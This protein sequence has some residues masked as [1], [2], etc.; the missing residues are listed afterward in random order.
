MR[1]RIRCIPDLFYD[2]SVWLA[3]WPRFRRASASPKDLRSTRLREEAPITPATGSRRS[4]CS[5]AG[6]PWESRST[7]RAISTLPIPAPTRSAKSRAARSTSSHAGCR[8]TR[9]TAARQRPRAWTILLRLP[10]ATVQPGTAG[11]RAGGQRGV[12]LS[13]CR[14][15][16]H[17]RKRVHLRPFQSRH[18]QSGLQ[19]HDQHLRWKWKHLLCPRPGQQRFRRHCGNFRADRPGAG[20]GGQSGPVIADL[21]PPVWTTRSSSGRKA[22]G[23]CIRYS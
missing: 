19:G 23:R 9:A 12:Q 16:G 21:W 13:G 22:T 7:P 1:D 6:P 5:S 17:L 10:W 15:G 8:A 14:G 11:R 2:S 18:P 20:C 3:S 4:R